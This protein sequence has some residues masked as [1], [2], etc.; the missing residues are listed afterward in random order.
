MAD[1]IQKCLQMVI[2]KNIYIGEGI[3]HESDHMLNYPQ[4]ADRFVKHKAPKDK[5]YKYAKIE[6]RF[7]PE[8]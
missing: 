8:I 1:Y 4:P 2:L 5:E 3:V 7:Y 6:K